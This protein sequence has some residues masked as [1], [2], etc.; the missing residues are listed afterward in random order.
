[1]NNRDRLAVTPN[2]PW[3]LYQ[4]AVVPPGWEILGTVQRGFDI[5]ALARNVRTGIYVMMRNGSVTML[6][7]RKVTAALSRSA[8]YGS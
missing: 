2:G 4:H 5:G 3:R 6:D 1:M 8:D 7:Q